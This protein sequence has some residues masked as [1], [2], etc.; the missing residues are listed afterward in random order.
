MNNATK[1][2]EKPERNLRPGSLLNF[3]VYL[4][5]RLAYLGVLLMFSDG[6]F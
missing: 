3:A 2:S 1:S 4:F 6:L 5:W